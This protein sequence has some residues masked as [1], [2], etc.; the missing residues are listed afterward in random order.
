MKTLFLRS[1]LWISALVVISFFQPIY[2]QA[3]CFHLGQ[4]FDC[5]GLPEGTSSDHFNPDG[6]ITLSNGG[7]V[8]GN[9]FDTPFV[10]QQPVISIPQ[11]I[12]PVVVSPSTGLQYN[13]IIT[14]NFLREAGQFPT[15]VDGQNALTAFNPAPRIGSAYSLST[16][17]GPRVYV[18]Y[19]PYR[20]QPASPQMVHVPKYEAIE[21]NLNKNFSDNWGF[22]PTYQ[23]FIQDNSYYVNDKW[24]LNDKWSFNLGVRYSESTP[25]D[26]E[27]AKKLLDEAGWTVGQDGVREKN[28]SPLSYFLST[29][30]FGRHDI[31]AGDQSNLFNTGSASHELKYGAGY[32]QAEVAQTDPYSGTTYSQ[33]GIGYDVARDVSLGVRYIHLNIPRVIEDM[34]TDPSSGSN[35]VSPRLGI[36]YDPKGNGDWVFSASYGQYVSNLANSGDTNTSAKID[37][38]DAKR[39]SE[40][41]QKILD[42]SDAQAAPVPDLIFDFNEANPPSQPQVFEDDKQVM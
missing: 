40:A 29:S 2:A 41:F 24:K 23:Y 18:Y 9:F 27:K 32:R 31:K 11:P 33:G 16:N 19:S 1:I 13:G 5:K 37:L 39:L 4:A 3:Q 10:A 6:S 17:N 22:Y 14:E 21:V 34:S 12:V 7:V 42:Q 36:T 30:S 8:P 20:V 38:N 15:T 26:A 28:Y 25:Y 35:N